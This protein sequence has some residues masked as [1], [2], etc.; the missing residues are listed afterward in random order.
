MN[1]GRGCRAVNPSVCSTYD[2]RRRRER[3]WMEKRQ[4]EKM[5]RLGTRKSRHRGILVYDAPGAAR[6]VTG[7]MLPVYSSEA[8]A[9]YEE[10]VTLL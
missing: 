10:S 2:E 8:S 7:S 1:S 4:E 9:L 5:T 3:E 6:W